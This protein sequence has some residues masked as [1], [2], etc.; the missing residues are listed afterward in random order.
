MG[1]MGEAEQNQ[2][3]GELAGPDRLKARD[4]QFLKVKTFALR[5]KAA[6]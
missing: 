3:N 1:H 6:M 5:F 2:V 4:L